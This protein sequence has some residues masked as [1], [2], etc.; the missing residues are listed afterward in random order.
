VYASGFCVERIN[1]SRI[2]ADENP[3]VNDR[4]SIQR[5]GVWESEGPF[6]LN[7]DTWPADNPAAFAGWNRVFERSPQPFQAGALRSRTDWLGGV[8]DYGQDDSKVLVTKWSASPASANPEHPILRGIK[9][10][11]YEQEEFFPS[12][13]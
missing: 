13:S 2:R 5:G 1:V 3:S 9:P 12:R 10:W 4:L 8:A 11:T 6:N 7:L